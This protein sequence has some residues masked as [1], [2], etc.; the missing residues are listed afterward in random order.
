MLKGLNDLNLMASKG[1]ATSNDEHTAF[2]V[3]LAR[4]FA[5]VGREDV[6]MM[7]DPKLQSQGSSNPPQIQ[8]VALCGL[9]GMG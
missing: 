4:N 8:K 3:P 9:G 2:M 6:S 5:F 7:I 1:V